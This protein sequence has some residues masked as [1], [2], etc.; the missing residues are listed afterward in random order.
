M[1]LCKSLKTY[2]PQRCIACKSHIVRF[3]I[4]GI[5]KYDSFLFTCSIKTYQYSLL[6]HGFVGLLVNLNRFEVVHNVQ[7]PIELEELSVYMECY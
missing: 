2:L 3:T 5:T 6:N 1:P 4:H 7:R